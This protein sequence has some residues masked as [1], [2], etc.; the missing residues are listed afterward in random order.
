MEP[1][2]AGCQTVFRFVLTITRI[3]TQEVTSKVSSLVTNYNS[4]VVR[5]LRFVRPASYGIVEP[6]PLLLL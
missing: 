1:V 3:E 2:T 6:S 5:D 4:T